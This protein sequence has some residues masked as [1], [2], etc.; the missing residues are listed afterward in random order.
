MSSMSTLADLRPGDILFGPI[1]GAAGVLISAGQILLA[2]AEPGMIWRQ[3]IEKWFRIRHA[4]VVVEARQ[5]PSTSMWRSSRLVQAMAGGTEEIEMTP[6]RHWTP[7]YVYLRP[8]YDEGQPF[9]IGY[10]NRSQGFK[11]AHAARK[12]T[13]TPY[14]FMTYAAIPAY[15]RGL[16]LRRIK[17]V[18]AG[19]DT[20][21]CSRL[22]DAALRDAGWNA[23]DDGR[24][25][26]DVTPSEL[27]RAI[28]RSPGVTV[29]RPGEE[30]VTLS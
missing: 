15:R 4:G 10:E 11:V 25:P 3:G 7:E 21:M 27:Y 9:E 19:T 16:K 30:L 24:L 28:L 18:I 5:D 22:V 17:N 13:G 6:E 12:Y 1:H 29:I 23:F 26:G 2:A 14:D 8:K 20:M